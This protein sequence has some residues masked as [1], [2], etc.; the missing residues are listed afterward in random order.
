MHGYEVA[1]SSG[2]KTASVAIT[3]TPALLH[4]ITADA[5]TTGLIVVTV[6]DNAT[7]A[8]GT[9]LERIEIVAGT[10]SITRNFTTPISAN[11]G[12]FVE[13]LNNTDTACGAI[14][15]FSSL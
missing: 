8:S 14:V 1:T 15:H 2:R 12:L 13:I 4:S 10:S 9:A 5:D 11:N 3:A 7:A 6:F